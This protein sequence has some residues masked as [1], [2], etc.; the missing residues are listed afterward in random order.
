VR[1]AEVMLGQALVDLLRESARVPR[2]VGAA[3]GGYERRR[4][5]S[6]RRAEDLGDDAPG[7]RDSSSLSAS[8]AAGTSMNE[9][10]GQ[11]G[12]GGCATAT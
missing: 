5:K 2:L 4:P 6:R 10:R 8:A 1:V 11:R 9:A 12:L 3:N 7:V